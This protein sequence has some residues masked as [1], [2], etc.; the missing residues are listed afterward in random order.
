MLSWWLPPT[1]GLYQIRLELATQTSPSGQTPM[2]Y[3]LEGAT[4]WYNITVNDIGPSGTFVPTNEPVCGT[5]PAGTNLTGTL[6][7]EAPYFGSYYAAV[8]NSAIDIVI[9][10]G[11]DINPGFTEIPSP[12]PWTWDSASAPPCGYVAALEVCDRTI[13]N[14][15]PY[16][17]GCIQVPPGGIGFCVGPALGK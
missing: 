2:T 16:N 15:V 5:F 4:D 10:G 14:S 13:Y 7:A 12:V 8:Y 6:T 1:G 11:T 3:K 17:P 9:D